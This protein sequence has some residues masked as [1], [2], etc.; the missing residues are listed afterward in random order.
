MKPSEDYHPSVSMEKYA[1]KMHFY[2]G[3]WLQ[4]ILSDATVKDRL[5]KLV[6]PK[7]AH[8]MKWMAFLSG[9]LCTAG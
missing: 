1:Y 4:G 7:H 8:L 6:M 2:Q 9:F 5:A 3:V